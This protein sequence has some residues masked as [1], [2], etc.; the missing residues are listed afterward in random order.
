MSEHIHMAIG[1]FLYDIGAS[2]DAVNSGYFQP[3]VEAFASG[4][5][6]AVLSSCHDFRGV[7]FLKSIDASDIINFT[8]ALYELFKQA[9]EENGVRHVCQV[10]ARMEEQCIFAERSLADTFPTFIGLLVQFNEPGINRFPT[11]FGTLKQMVHLK[12]NLQAMVSSQERNWGNGN[13]R[14]GFYLNPKYFYSFDGDIPKAIWSGMYDCTEKFVPD[15]SVQDKIIKE[16]NSYKNAAGDFGRKMAVRARV[17]MLPVDST[18]DDARLLGNSHG[19]VKDLGAG[20]HDYGIFNR[21]KE[22]ASK[23]RLN[24]KLIKPLIISH[25]PVLWNT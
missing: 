16:V 9:V 21:V 11:N 3:M 13:V 15:L 4:G 22:K 6:D 10:I 19:E 5:S 20:F 1:R 2:S 7:V 18:S 12:H 25:L 17:S 23:K 24:T 8:D 14:S